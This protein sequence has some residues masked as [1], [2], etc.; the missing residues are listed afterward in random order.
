MQ[1]VIIAR[2]SSAAD[3]V[4]IAL[5]LAL[6]YALVAYSR[7]WEASFH[8]AVD[9]DLSLYSLPYYS[10]FSAMRG[11]AAFVLSLGSRWSSATGLQNHR[12]LS[13]S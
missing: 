12:K 4:V 7:E 9:I 10:L 3:A 6:I 8:A 1:K 5:V 11:M 2:N 13:A